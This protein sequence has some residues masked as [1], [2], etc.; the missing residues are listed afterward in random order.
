MGVA[1]DET[2]ST[3]L[4]IPQGILITEIADDG[5]FANSSAKPKNIITKVDG[6]RV[7]TFNQVYSVLAKHKVG[8]KINVEICKVDSSN[9]S[10]SKTATI[11]VTLVADKG[12]TQK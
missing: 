3:A 7:K 10:N 5:S 2:A 8:D 11:N 1:V 9:P 4:G 6:T 12:E